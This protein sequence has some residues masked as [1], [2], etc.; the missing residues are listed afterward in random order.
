[1]GFEEYPSSLRAPW[2]WFLTEEAKLKSKT[3]LRRLNLN[4]HWELA[5][6]GIR[7]RAMRRIFGIQSVSAMSVDLDGEEEEEIIARHGCSPGRSSSIYISRWFRFS[8]APL[9][10]VL[11]TNQHRNFC[12]FQLRS[13][14]FFYYLKAWMVLSYGL[15]LMTTIPLNGPVKTQPK[16]LVH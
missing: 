11:L 7:T 1:M 9:N 3:L 6:K 8:L 2:G 15:I 16:K 13:L 10:Y 5:P 14:D 12:V 4:S